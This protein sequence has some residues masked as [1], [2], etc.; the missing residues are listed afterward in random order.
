MAVDDEDANSILAVDT[1]RAM[2]G[3]MGMH[4]APPNAWSTFQPMQVAPHGGQILIQYKWCHLIAKFSI[5]EIIKVMDLTPGSVV[6]LVMIF[7]NMSVF[8]PSP[9]CGACFKG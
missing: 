9:H 8:R 1:N 7:S 4:V 3:N 5:I 6:P 2:P